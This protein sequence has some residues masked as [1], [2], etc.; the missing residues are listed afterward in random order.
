MDE[1]A[2]SNRR[3]RRITIGFLMLVVGTA[4]LVFALIRPKTH[5]EV[6]RH[7]FKIAQANRPGFVASRFRVDQ[8]NSSADKVYWVVRMSPKIGPAN[9]AL[10]VAVPKSVISR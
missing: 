1:E 9:Q 2:T 5:R 6:V 10:T 7:A 8:V 3:R 4:S